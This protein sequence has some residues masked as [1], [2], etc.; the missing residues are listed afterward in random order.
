MKTRKVL[1]LVLSIVMVFSLCST[2]F[3][4]HLTDEVTELEA[5]NSDLSM[6]LAT[7]A[8]V[9]FENNGVLPLD[10]VE[11]KTVAVFGSASEFTIKGGTGSGD[12]NQRS[13]DHIDEA[14]IAAGWELA[15]P[16]WMA[17][18]EA[19][20]IPSGC[21]GNNP[22]SDLEITA[23][24]MAEAVANTDLAVYAVARNAGEFQDRNARGG[25]YYL[26][27]L[28][29]ANLEAIAANFEDVI[30]VLNTCVVDT[31]FIREIEN[32]DAVI[33][34]GNGGQRGSEAL[35]K[36][37]EGEV[38]PSGKLTD[39]WPLNIEDYPSYEGFGMNDG[40]QNTEYYYE[41]IYNG[42]RYFDTWGMDVAYEFGFG[43][44]Y[45]E[46]D[47]DVVDVAVDGEEVEVVVDVTNV[48]GEY[49]GKEV[50]QVYFSAPDGRLEKPYQELAAYGKTD[51][52]EPGEKQTLTLSYATT[53]MSSYDEELAAY[54]MDAGE[55]IIRVGNSS[56]NTEVAAVATLAEM[57]ITEQLSNQVTLEDGVVLDEWSK[58]GQ[59][60]ITYDG[61]AAEI[62]AA[63]AFEIAAED[64]P[65]ANNA[66]EY[67][68]ETT[69]TYL[70]AD[71]AATYEA[72]ENIIL[73]TKTIA[74]NLEHV[75]NRG[76]YA[77]TIYN[78]V[79][80]IVP[81]LPEGIEKDTAKLTDVYTGKITME[82][83]VAAMSDYELARI[84]VG[85]AGTPTVGPNGEQVGGSADSVQGGA[86]QTTMELLN[87]RHVPSMP[88]ADGPAGIRITQSY[89]QNGVQYYQ[90]CTA[91][92]AGTCMAG[93]WDTD[94][95]YLMG[96][97][98]GK[99]MIEYGVTTWLAPAL[100]IHRN[101]L[102]GRNFEYFS[103]DPL[104]SGIVAANLTAGVQATPGI[105]VTLKHFWGNSQE[106]NRNA[107]NNVISE[108][109][110]R[111]IYL[112]GFE[113]CV[114][115]AQPTCIM[116]CY[117]GNNGWP[118]SDDFD[119]N[120]D[121]TRGE[122]GFKGYVMTDWGGGQSSP[123]V[124]KHGGCD[125]TMPGSGVNQVLN[126]VG[127]AA[128]TFRAD[129]SIQSAGSFEVKAGGSVEYRAD[130]ESYDVLADSVHEAIAAGQAKF[131][132]TENG[133]YVTW[134]GYHV[135]RIV[136]GDVQKSAINILNVAIQSKDM[137]NLGEAVGVDVE[138]TPWTELQDAPIVNGWAQSEKSEVV[139]VGLAA[140]I[141]EADCAV[142]EAVVDITYTGEAAL[143]SV[144][145][146]VDSEIEIADVIVADG[147]SMEYN[148]AEG[149]IVI[150]EAAGEEIDG[151]LA[152]LVYDISANPWLANGTY[153]IDLE[154]V[155]ATDTAE[156]HIVVKGVDGAVI[157]NN[158]YAAGD[159]NLDGIVSNADVIAIARYLV[160]LVEFN[161][162]QL[163]AA[164][165]NVDGAVDNV[166]LVKVARSI[167]AAA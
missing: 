59:T 148:E 134:Y 110:A 167:V 86:G 32:I 93:T 119:T 103:E 31:D 82:Q 113:I 84:T 165:V 8:Y 120:W 163:I 141:V 92:P 142:G 150:W 4:A 37:I 135:G 47:I 17:K 72:R 50:V 28:E 71:D 6:E 10:D 36:V 51:E 54:I 89:R 16:T 106:T 162:E 55:Y 122:W 95:N 24:E 66:S 137:V 121:I 33:Y 48:G 115:L 52:L 112:K 131:C 42:Y 145:F 11:E 109:A 111:E 158:S 160:N 159:A 70:F 62:A 87:T 12:V 38:T 80:E 68:D 64:L 123:H 63:P 61:E 1:A 43:G 22:K 130:V 41:G 151:V 146:Y 117:N 74:G 5:T 29:R 75:G 69:T 57:A 35:V 104:V 143:T 25:D 81:D 114:K 128:P 98:I 45:T 108:R 138:I 102:C 153:A 79:V 91:F 58:A 100:N 44:S 99:E 156:E 3:A 85:G 60:P 161:A 14:F 9:L 2:A 46:F 23:E 30:V 164:D 26:S 94:L 40:N 127:I 126:Y 13:R 116:N 124:Q 18:M 155:D 105:G 133:D 76:G 65:Y 73:R 83:F 144:R 67:D 49:S 21:F 157:I 96:E 97:A 129:G 20:R 101:A 152:T 15:N 118:G 125:M 107:E 90:F 34:M 7:N 56:R 154:V 77:E 132:H 139:N 27:D 140:G 166:D 147:Y 53:D 19:Q 136:R 78:E 149:Y 88:N 39:T